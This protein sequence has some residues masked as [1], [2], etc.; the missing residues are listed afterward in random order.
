[1]SFKTYAQGAR[2][3]YIEGKGRA[4]SYVLGEEDSLARAAAWA[5]T[6]TARDQAFWAAGYKRGYLLAVE[7]ST[8]PDEYVNAPLPDHRGRPRQFEPY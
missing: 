7:G 6:S 5:N 3:G 4:G 1:M 2:C 8:L